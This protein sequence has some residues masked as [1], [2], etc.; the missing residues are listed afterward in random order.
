MKNYDNVCYLRLACSSIV[1]VLITNKK[2]IIFLSG[3]VIPC[4]LG[5]TFWV[6]L[7]LSTIIRN[8]DDKATSCDI[9]MTYEY[10]GSPT[11]F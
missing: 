5:L 7:A 3:I 10:L 11:Y 2:L 1:W 9:I 6:H 8:M 4:I